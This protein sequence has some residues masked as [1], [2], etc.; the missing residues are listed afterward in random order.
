MGKTSRTNRNFMFSNLTPPF[1]I[2][3]SFWVKFFNVLRK[4]SVDVESK[5]NERWPLMGTYRNY[6]SFRPLR[7]PEIPSQECRGKAVPG[8]F[9]FSVSILHDPSPVKIPVRPNSSVKTT[10]LSTRTTFFSNFRRREPSRHYEPCRT[11][12]VCAQTSGVARTGVW[13][14]DRRP[15]EVRLVPPSNS[16][17]SLE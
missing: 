2:D 1:Y 8:H 10:F 11:D 17:G 3:P 13:T 14:A 5:F 7:P 15:H 6:P 9:L 4:V 12:R 16:S